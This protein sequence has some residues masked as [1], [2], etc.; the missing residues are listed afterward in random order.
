MTSYLLDTNVV[1]SLA[2]TEG[3]RP[4]SHA[5]ISG[6]I[7]ANSDRLFFSV[8]TALEIEAGVIKLERSAA[9]RRQQRM[10]EWFSSILLH[11]ADRILPLDL[12]IVRLASAMT[13]R[14]KAR[15]LY[16]GMADTVIAAT[17]ISHGLILL[18]RNLRHFEV[19]EI[20][21]VNPFESLPI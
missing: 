1:S 7:V 4:A 8:V 14:S 5:G 13:D 9:G 15:G 21:T 19:F 2:P 11:Y 18:T 10:S 16:P 6:W 20:E 17:A 12:K 3:E